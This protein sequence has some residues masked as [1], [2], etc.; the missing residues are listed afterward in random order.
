[1]VE[2]KRFPI[3]LGKLEEA[4]SETIRECKKLQTL[5]LFWT[6][7]DSLPESLKECS[8]LTLIGSFNLEARPDWLKDSPNLKRLII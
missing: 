3:S 7:I 2:E 1:M 6:K 4:K 5:N 8:N